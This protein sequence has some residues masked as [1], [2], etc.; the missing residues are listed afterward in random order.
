LEKHRFLKILKQKII[1]TNKL[2]NIMTSDDLLKN[3]YFDNLN[4]RLP[5]DQMHRIMVIGVGGG[6]GNAVNNLYANIE[7]ATLVVCN[8]DDQV[9]QA[10]PIATQILL[11]L[12]ELP[13]IDI[14]KYSEEERTQITEYYDLSQGKAGYGAG[15][16]PLIAKLA[17]ENTMPEITEVINNGVTS[18]VFITATMGGGT[19][20]GA[21]A[22]IAKECQKLK[23]LTVGV[24]TL[25]FKWEGTEKMEMAWKGVMEMKPYLDAL[26]I[27]LNDNLQD[28]KIIDK[29]KGK[30]TIRINEDGSI[31]QSDLFKL[32]DS[33]LADAV[34]SVVDIV[35]NRGT[36]NLDFADVSKALKNGGGTIM[37]SGFG[38]GKKRFYNAMVDALESPLL[39]NFDIGKASRIIMGFFSSSEYEMTNRELLQIEEFQKRFPSKYWFKWGTY[40]DDELGE[41]AKVTIIA[42]GAENEDMIPS[43]LEQMLNIIKDQDK[44]PLKIFDNAD[45][46]LDYQ[47]NTA[48]ARAEL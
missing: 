23:K 16:T 30:V 37:D 42:T 1:I 43:E 31:P 22:V 34:K 44:S 5:Q 25:P 48:L 8:T 41:K 7:K 27:I 28:E 9:L 12:P 32:A 4:Y 29:F 14:G 10:S 39:C 33:V 24:V 19:G 40:I 36:K 26:L 18:M 20:T 45:A 21:A 2:K 3:R 38:T 46:L 35:E 47:Q 17:A 15:N 11:K 6:G 13:V